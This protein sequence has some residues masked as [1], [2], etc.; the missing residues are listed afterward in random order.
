MQWKDY[1]CRV[2]QGYSCK[3]IIIIIV[4]T[5]VGNEELGESDNHPISP[6]TDRVKPSNQRT[7]RKTNSETK[8]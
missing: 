5:K 2:K 3:V 4:I 7:K 8:I 1:S 6:K